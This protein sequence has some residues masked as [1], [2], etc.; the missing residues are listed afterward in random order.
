MVDSRPLAS[1]NDGAA[2]SAIL[3]FVAR[4][5][6]EGG[7]EFAPPA[8]RVATFDND[9]TLCCEQPL[10]TQFF[11][12]F[13]RVK[14]LSAKDPTMAERQPFKAVLEHDY[15]TLFGLGLQALYELAFATHAGI[16]DEEF[17]EIARGWLATAKHPKVGRL[18]KE[19]V[20]R[21]QVELLA[22]LRENGGR[23]RRL[24]ARV[25]GRSLRRPARAGDR[26]ECK[27]ALRCG[28]RQGFAVEALRT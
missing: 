8:E 19:C 16:T 18:F 27:T 21:P 11:F 1:W 14:E 23:R 10:Q 3:D 13:N 28:R 6:K 17:I 22:Y 5:T 20:Y 12:A 25:R 2:K 26:L 15:N 24:H 9:G 7:P 4:V